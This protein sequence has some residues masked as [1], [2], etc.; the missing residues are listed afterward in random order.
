MLAIKRASATL[1][2]NNLVILK[3]T[4][5]KLNASRPVATASPPG[6]WP[7]VPT[8]VVEDKLPPLVP[9][10][11]AIAHVPFLH[12]SWLRKH[13]LIPQHGEYW[14]AVARLGD[15]VLKIYVK[16]MLRQSRANGADK[17]VLPFP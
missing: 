8:M 16:Q 11:P 12:D 4:L 5:G 3:V 2:T 13:Q 7:K 6:H 1:K 17:G 9:L 10:P 14:R 15:T